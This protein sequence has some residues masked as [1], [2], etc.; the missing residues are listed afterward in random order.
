MRFIPDDPEPIF[1]LRRRGSPPKINPKNGSIQLRYEGIDTL[2][3]S[4]IT[5]FSSDA[6][7]SNLELAAT[8]GGTTNAPG[9]IYS[10]QIGPH[11][12][13]IAFVFAGEAPGKTG[14]ETLNRP[15]F[16]GER[17]VQRVRRPYRGVG[18]VQDVVSQPLPAACNL[19]SSG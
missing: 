16:T 7:A 15:G 19:A 3:K 11:G 9:Y 6:T 1:R 5:P 10:N 18:A 14:D 13:P 4:A 17:F 2:E 8:E 12:R